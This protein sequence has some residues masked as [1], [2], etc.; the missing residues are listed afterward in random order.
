MTA[1]DIMS[2]N[3]ERET[4]YKTVWNCDS[5]I[6]PVTDRGDW[7]ESEVLFERTLNARGF[8]VEAMKKPPHLSVTGVEE[9]GYER[10]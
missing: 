3:A 10:L 6:I 1:E 7:R 4:Q 9:G 8:M 2:F 5:A